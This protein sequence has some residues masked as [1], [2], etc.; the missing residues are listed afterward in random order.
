MYIYPHYHCAKCDALIE[1]GTEYLKK[2]VSERGY[3]G[4]E[5]YCS[6]ACAEYMQKREKSEKRSKYITYLLLGI[7]ITSALA[8]LFIF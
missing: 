7:A 3:P 8:L 1:K 4:F 5:Y 2:R 6:R